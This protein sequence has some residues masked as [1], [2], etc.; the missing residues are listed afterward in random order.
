MNIKKILIAAVCG[1][2]DMKQI[3]TSL[4]LFSTFSFATTI[5]VPA[6]YSTIQGGIDAANDGDMVLV[7]AGT[8]VENINFNGKNISVIGADRETTIIDGNQNGS[9]VYI[10]ISSPETPLLTNLTITNGTGTYDLF[11]CE[12][13]GAT[14]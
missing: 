2:F 8:Y 10:N 5:N 4:I 6:D 3:L 11:D 7:Q 1:R 12:K 14:V 13:Q 9:V